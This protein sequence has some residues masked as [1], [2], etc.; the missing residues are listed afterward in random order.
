MSKSTNTMHIR[1]LVMTWLAVAAMAVAAQ[2]TAAVAGATAH[3][4]TLSQSTDA[5]AHPVTLSQNT[6]TARDVTLSQSTDATAR[7]AALSLFTVEG[8]YA[9]VHDS[10]LS[11]V[12]YDGWNLAMGYET[13]RHA[14]RPWLWQLAAGVDY[15]H[16]ENP[17]RNNTLHKVMG[18]ITFAMQRR[19]R[20]VMARRL[21]L[22]AGPMAQLRAG[23]VYNP[24]ASNNTV[25]ARAYGGV[26]LAAMAALDTRVWRL[27]VTLRY[28]AQLP[29]L[30]VFFAPDYGESYYEIYLGNRHG[31]A[32]VGWWG[33]RLDLNHYLGADLHLGRTV[34]RVGYRGR[35]ERWR[36]AGIHVHDVT[37]SLV[38]AIGTR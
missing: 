19:W 15:S 11:Q 31:L 28:Q 14:A 5:T 1:A 13:L 12:T 30:G 4:V 7:D 2:D 16:V 26:G 36:V 18:D 21:D 25:T 33:N 34:L 24:A 6:A 17:A 8:G 3:L 38:L 9:S 23:V 35:L 20:G 37:H 22:S 10:Y 27:P 32:H 29:A